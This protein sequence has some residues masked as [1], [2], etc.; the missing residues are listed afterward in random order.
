METLLRSNKESIINFALHVIKL[1]LRA[2]D[3]EKT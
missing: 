3:S 1:E 2:G